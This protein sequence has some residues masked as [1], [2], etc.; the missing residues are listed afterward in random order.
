MKIKVTDVS[1]FKD[2]V[3]IELVDC[4]DS[5]DGGNRT[6][7]GKI[8]NIKDNILEVKFHNS[9]KLCSCTDKIIA[10]KI[11]QDCEIIE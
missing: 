6:Y 8:L 2:V 5:L 4:V 10:P 7:E 9:V 3:W 11:Y 1:L